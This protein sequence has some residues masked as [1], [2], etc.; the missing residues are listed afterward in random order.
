[1]CFYPT[2]DGWDNSKNNWDRPLYCEDGFHWRDERVRQPYYF[3]IRALELD[4]LQLSCEKTNSSKFMIGWKHDQVSTKLVV[5]SCNHI[6]THKC[7]KVELNFFQSLLNHHGAQYWVYSMLHK[8]FEKLLCLQSRSKV[9]LKLLGGIVF[10]NTFAL[11]IWYFITF[12]LEVESVKVPWITQV[13]F[14]VVIRN[15]L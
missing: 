3:R 1:M 15:L 4:V 12:T 10:K 2:H 6:F 9:F 13:I 5:S 8:K 7:K 11:K 14:K